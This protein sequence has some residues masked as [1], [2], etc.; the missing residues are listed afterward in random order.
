VNGSE[1]YEVRYEEKREGVS[2]QEV[3]DAIKSVGNSRE[4]VEKKL[5][6]YPRQAR[7]LA[8]TTVLTDL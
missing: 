8:N 2:T 3:K 1:D 6:R 7:T 4:K 5:E